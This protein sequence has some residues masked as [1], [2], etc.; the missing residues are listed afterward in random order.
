MQQCAD[1]PTESVHGSHQDD[2]PVSSGPEFVSIELQALLDA[3]VDAVVVIDSHGRIEHFSR[4]AERLF[5]YA[6]QE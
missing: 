6:A 2:P 1:T 5:G 4:A 3:A